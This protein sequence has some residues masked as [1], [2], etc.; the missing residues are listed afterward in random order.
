M[1]NGGGPEANSQVVPSGGPLPVDGG[2]LS[3][4]VGAREGQAMG[5]GLAGAVSADRPVGR[6][7]TEI[8]SATAAYSASREGKRLNM[9]GF[10]S[11]LLDREE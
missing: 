10:N 6:D 7:H 8:G 4:T 9:L 3:M 1:K 5:I 11:H 2:Q